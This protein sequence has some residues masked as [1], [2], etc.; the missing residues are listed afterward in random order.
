MSSAPVNTFYLVD[1]ASYDKYMQ[2]KSESS[3]DVTKYPKRVANKIRKILTYLSS[4]GIQWNLIGSTVTSNTLP[5]NLNVLSYSAYV[6]TGQGPEPESLSCFLDVLLNIDVPLKLFC[7]KIQKTLVR[8]RKTRQRSK[9][10][11]KQNGAQTE[12][13]S[14]EEG[15][16]TSD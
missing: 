4:I 14:Q 11:M 13:S 1:S 2:R 5:Q 12:K 7:A 10:K 15:E 16:S 3:L 8:M 6:V 9:R